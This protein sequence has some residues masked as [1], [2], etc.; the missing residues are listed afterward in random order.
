MFEFVPVTSGSRGKGSAEQFPEGRR[1]LGSTRAVRQGAADPGRLESWGSQC[2]RQALLPALLHLCNTTPPLLW[3]CCPS[4]QLRLR[5]S[6]VRYFGNCI[7]KKKNNLTPRFP[8]YFMDLNNDFSH[9]WIQ[10]QKLF[11]DTDRDIISYIRAYQG[12]HLKQDIKRNP[13]VLTTI[14]LDQDLKQTNKQLKSP[15]PFHLLLALQDM[16]TYVTSYITGKKKK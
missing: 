1:S 10:I 6:Q 9:Q 2:S 7:Q 11:S 4:H 13:E 3:H 5:Y 15:S 8:G 16:H 12:P 14:L